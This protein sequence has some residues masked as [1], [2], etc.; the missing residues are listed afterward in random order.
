M[1]MNGRLRLVSDAEI[2]Q[3]AANP[4]T[5]EEFLFGEEDA[6]EDRSDL[7]L[8]KMWHAI[9]F[10]LTGGAHEERPPLDFLALGG[11]EMG[12]DL[13]YGAPRAC[14]S[15]VVREIAKALEALTPDAALARFDPDRMSSL[16]IY[17]EVWDRE[18]ERAD[19]QAWLRQSYTALRDL[20]LR[21]AR[22]ELGLLVYIV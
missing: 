13:G 19:Q 15:R 10:L 9:H 3:L 11:E 7:D 18:D 1:S 14:R 16:S 17:P 12:D 6:Y 2:D 20:V 8:D 21:A 4:D 22:D 5:V